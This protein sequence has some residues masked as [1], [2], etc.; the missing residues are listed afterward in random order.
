MAYKC[1]YCGEMKECRPYAKDGAM[2]CFKCSQATPERAAE[3]ERMFA[4]HLAGC[5]Q[6]AVVVIGEETGPRPVGGLKQCAT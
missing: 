3:T 2:V 5:G 6:A 4:V 1:C